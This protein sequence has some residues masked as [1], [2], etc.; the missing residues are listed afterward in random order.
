MPARIC[1]GSFGCPQARWVGARGIIG[2]ADTVT[3]AR[4]K[5]ELAEIL[6][7]PVCKGALGL[8]VNL[9]EAGEILTGALRCP[10]CN[11]E[12][13]IEDAIPNLLPASLRE[14]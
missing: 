2:R 13:L 11:E 9:E 6:A 7:C 5:H 14:P 10:A 12:Y 3:G 1:T 8:T 4:V